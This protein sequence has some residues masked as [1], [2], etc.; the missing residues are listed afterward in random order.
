MRHSLDVIT[1][2][3]T[4]MEYYKRS[5]EEDKE[6]GSSL[7]AGKEMDHWI[8]NCKDC[9]AA[10][11]SIEELKKELEE[12]EMMEVYQSLFGEV[13]E[14]LL[15]MNLN[16][17]PVDAEK[18]PIVINN[19]KTEIET[20]EKI[21]E[22]TLGYPLN[23]NSHPQVTK[24]LFE[25]LKM[26]PYRDRDGKTPAD[27]KTLDK[28]AYKYQS[29]IP[30]LIKEI[31][32]DKSF[33]SIFD[34]KNIE[35]GSFRCSYS[36][37]TTKTGRL[38][39]RKAFSG[40]GRNLQNVKR[41][42]VRRFF[43][44]EEGH[45][46]VGGDQC[47]P[48]GTLIETPQ[49]KVS[50][51]EM[52]R[53]DYVYTYRDNAIHIGQVKYAWCTGIK[54]LMEVQL[55]SG[56]GKY[57]TIRAT[58]THKVYLSNETKCMLKDLNRGDSL[59]HFQ[60]TITDNRSLLRLNK[61]FQ[62]RESR[63][64]GEDLLH[65]A[66]WAVIHHKDSNPLND[67]LDNLEVLTLEEH[68]KIHN[69]LTHVNKEK[70][71]EALRESIASKPDWN[72]GNKNPRW[73]ASKDRV[74]Q[75]C[76]KHYHIDR[77][78]RSEKYC[79]RDCYFAH[80]HPRLYTSIAEGNFTVIS[81]KHLEKKSLVYNMEVVPDHNYILVNGIVSSN[82]QA[83]ARVVAYFSRD[84]NYIRAAESGRIH[85]DVGVTVYGD[86]NFSNKDPRYRAVKALV[87]GTDYGMGPYT[88]AETA[89]IPRAKAKEDWEKFHKEF[90]GIRNVYYKYVE[91]CIRNNRTLYNVF[92]R[93]QIFFS[94][95]SESVFK[96]GYAFIPQSS[97]SDLNKKALKKVS[98]HYRILLE[99]H[100]G[101]I[102]SVP[103]KEVKYGIEALQE[104]YH[105]PFTI[106][107]IERMIPIEIKVGPNWADMEAIE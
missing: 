57:V 39:S 73:D 10:Y 1:S 80:E 15:E 63:I 21:I 4:D 78:H 45:L 93:R 55:R 32:E 23:V 87:H 106:W 99:Q 95:I 67:H 36:L 103:K 90:P 6:K 91:E 100:D 25:D 71:I 77:H 88:F 44:P 54:P 70:R 69:G 26:L 50:I 18:L 59:M 12:E 46:M 5:D 28:L 2:I 34:V 14:P 31:R 56:S 102:I 96:A 104:A 24:A 33:M 76:N 47:W 40:K 11:W 92:G 27:A 105:I 17:V 7:R 65:A 60:R 37:A 16:G 75:H 89:N 38:S 84:E 8:Y 82:C 94:R 29:E 97:S 48:P 64:I 49:G 52:K 53:G 61:F 101:L 85:L 83:E 68:N 3:Y 13:I 72:V 107:G 58:P 51:E 43:I 9:S 86:P 42:P 41:G 22:D 20:K 74:C 81:K 98:K 62:K 19:M 79:C 30:T 35:N 66:S